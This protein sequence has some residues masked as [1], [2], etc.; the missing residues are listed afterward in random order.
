MIGWLAFSI[1][2]PTWR[3]ADLLKTRLHRERRTALIVKLNRSYLVISSLA[4][5]VTITVT[6]NAL[7]AESG[8]LPHLL[9]LLWGWF[10]WSRAFEVFYAFYRDAFDK[11]VD[12]V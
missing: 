8:R 1:L 11:L 3:L 12:K 6:G 4:V 10:L 9:C 5:I 7:V 2:S